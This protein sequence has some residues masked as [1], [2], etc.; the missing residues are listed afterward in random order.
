MTKK[1][2][3]AAIALA[4]VIVGAVFIRQNQTTSIETMEDGRV[5]VET[6]VSREC[7]LQKFQFTCSAVFEVKQETDGTYYIDDV[8]APFIQRKKAPADYTC[9]PADTQEDPRVICVE[10][11]QSYVVKRWIQVKKAGSDVQTIP[12]AAQFT[13]S[14]ETGEMRVTD[15]MT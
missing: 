3:I 13:V 12:I 6:T 14:P 10:E 4:A 15:Y 8:K 1:R 9:A 11:G 7:D 5:G 2:M